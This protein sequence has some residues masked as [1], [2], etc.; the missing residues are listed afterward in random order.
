MP[1]ISSAK[2]DYPFLFLLGTAALALSPRYRICAR[3]ERVTQKGEGA[4]KP[5]PFVLCGLSFGGLHAVDGLGGQDFKAVG[6]QGLGG[7]LAVIQADDDVGLALIS[8]DEGVHI[9]HVET[10]VGE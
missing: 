9:L 4:E 7:L 3:G 5:S 6:V 1:V 2:I 10:L 8:A